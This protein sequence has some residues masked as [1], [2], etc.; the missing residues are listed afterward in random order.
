M[1]QD[2]IGRLIKDIRQKNNLTQQKFAEKYGVTY[3]AV[4]KWENGKNIPDITILKKIC[5]DYDI[6]L[7]DLLEG[8]HAETEESNFSKRMMT[9]TVVIMLIIVVISLCVYLLP[10]KNSNDF[11][12]KTLSTTCEDF[13]LYGS[14]AYS[15]TKTSIY[16]SNITYCGKDDEVFKEINCTL[17]EN[18]GDLK[19]KISSYHYDKEI[20][21]DEFLDKVNFNIEHKS[22]SCKMYKENALHLEIE[23]KTINGETRFYKIPLEL[24]DNC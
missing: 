4:S 3:Q 8:N 23:A 13:N 22:D 15:D 11:E 24:D 21:I 2:K 7:N 1:D 12:F 14:I 20:T 5:E 17:Y 10:K 6:N 19:T 16:I 18:D 9:T